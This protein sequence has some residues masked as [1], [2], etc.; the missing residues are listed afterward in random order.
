MLQIIRGFGHAV[1]DIIIQYLLNANGTVGSISSM[2]RHA[3]YVY[4]YIYAVLVGSVVGF[5]QMHGIL[6]TKGCVNEEGPPWS[7][8]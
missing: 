1:L 5:A 8:C 3:M 6:S 7:A 4:I 2:H